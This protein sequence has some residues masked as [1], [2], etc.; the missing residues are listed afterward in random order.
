M[1][2]EYALTS[3]RQATA[4]APF[5]PLRAAVARLARRARA[6]LRLA[7][8]QRRAR[9]SH[10]ALSQL[11]DATLHDIGISRSEV[12]SIVSELGGRAAATRRRTDLDVWLSA[13]SRFRIRNIDSGL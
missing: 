13:S 6:A 3:T 8:R 7:M 5:A 10:Q 9:R 4:P 11:D 12:A 1:S 2:F